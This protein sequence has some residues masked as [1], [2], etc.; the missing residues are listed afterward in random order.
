MSACGSCAPAGRIWTGTR[1]SPTPSPRPPRLST[2]SDPR[3]N[4][5]RAAR[6]HGGAAPAL[7]IGPYGAAGYAVAGADRVAGQP[8]NLS[9]PSPVIKHARCMLGCRHSVFERLIGAPGRAAGTAGLE[10][11]SAKFWVSR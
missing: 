11:E 4:H 8:S 9:L 3:R 2:T 10:H 5:E 6:G 7:I 1:P